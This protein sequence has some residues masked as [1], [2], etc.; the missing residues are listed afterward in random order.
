MDRKKQKRL[1]EAGWRIG[2]AADF[3]RL[4]AAEEEL[5]AMKVALSVRLKKTREWR[6]ITQTELAR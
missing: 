4:S 5:V 6:G 3:L 2:S 1:Q